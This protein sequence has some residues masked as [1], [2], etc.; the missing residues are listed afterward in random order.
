MK[1]TLLAL[2]LTA[3]LTPSLS[4]AHSDEAH[5]RCDHKAGGHYSRM[6][7]RLD[8]KLDLSDEQ[9]SEVEA[10]FKEQH[11]KHKALRAEA[12]DKLK[13]ILNAEQQEK[14]EQLKAERKARW[15]E[16]RAEWNKQK[17]AE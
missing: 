13:G 2:L 10:V 8:S 16:K 4:Y 14:L 1:P 15:E 12:H 17:A 5:K 6:I 7:D 9:R 3:F 11:S